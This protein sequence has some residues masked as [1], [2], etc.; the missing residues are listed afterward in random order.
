LA[1]RLHDCPVCPSVKS[2]FEDKVVC[3]IGGIIVTE[4]ETDVL[5]GKNVPI[6]LVAFVGFSSMY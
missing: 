3:R 4:K 6:L 5:G 1:K 2:G